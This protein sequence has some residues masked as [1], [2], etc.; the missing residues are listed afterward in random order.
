VTRWTRSF[1]RCFG[2]VWLF[3]SVANL[4][5]ATDPIE[6]R[7]EALAE[8]NRH[9]QEQVRVQQQ[10]IDEL[11]AIVTGL[12]RSGE[13]QDRELQNLRT[14]VAEEPAASRTPTAGPGREVRV[15]GEAGFAFFRSGSAGFSPNSEF[16]VDDA[17]VFV[18]AAVMKDIYVFAGLELT[19]REAADEYFHVG[20]LYAD[21]ENVSAAW[22]QSGLLNVRAGRFSLP[23]GEE[24]QRRNM[25]D[26]PLI[27]HSLSDIWGIDEGVEIYGAL[28]RFSYVVAVQNGGHKTLRDYDADKAVVARVGFDPAPWA[29]VSASA[30][31]TGDL[32][33]AGDVTSEV[34][35]ANGFFRPL[36]PAATTT[37]FSASL[38]ELDAAAHWPGG[39]FR[40]AWGEAHF[41]D[42]DPATDNTRY[43][44]FYSLEGV[45]QLT[46]KWFGAARW[47]ELRA[48]G[49]Y[50][51]VGLGD[52]GTFVFRTPL[53]R[54]LRRLSVGFSYRFGPALVWKAEYAQERGHLS[55]GVRRDHED[56]LSSELALRF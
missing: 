8:Q 32:T 13:R 50:P 4:A 26:N 5:S 27:T 55:S 41:V 33:A 37:I 24:Y 54:D 16:R 15:S 30:M 23:F 38:F 22:G 3:A 21:F 9:L 35:L 44:R 14:Q 17:K 6:T 18:E 42:N 19:T 12:N 34:W 20:E 56:L 39:D 11:R 48:P 31:R 45:Q 52:F 25:L 53:T 28:D 29:H 40:T 51:L 46:G 47:S 1:L 10:E 2:A 7:L 43:L 36:G 49:G